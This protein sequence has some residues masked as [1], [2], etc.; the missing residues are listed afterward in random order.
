MALPEA[1]ATFEI[2]L[3]K[4]SNTP[5]QRTILHTGKQKNAC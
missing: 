5:I 1:H 3:M 4:S 2:H